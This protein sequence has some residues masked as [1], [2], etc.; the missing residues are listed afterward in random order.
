LQA[1]RAGALC[2][3]N[4]SDVPVFIK[5]NPRTIQS[6]ASMGFETELFNSQSIG[7]FRQL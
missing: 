2:K 7:T 4:S 3:L 5:G 1:K 6:I